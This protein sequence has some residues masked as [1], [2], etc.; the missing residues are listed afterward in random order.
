MQKVNVI[1]HGD[2]ILSEIICFNHIYP[3]LELFHK[4]NFTF[5][6][7]LDWQ[8]VIQDMNQNSNSGDREN[9]I[10]MVFFLFQVIIHNIG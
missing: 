4:F 7:P 6:S 1:K 5:S 3:S 2:Q 8:S 9:V 10:Q